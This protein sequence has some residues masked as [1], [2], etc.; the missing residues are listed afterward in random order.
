M[1]YLMREQSRWFTLKKD[2]AVAARL[3]AV[4]EPGFVLI[5][6]TLLA[7]LIL[8]YFSLE[9]VGHYLYGSAIPNFLSASSVLFIELVTRYGFVLGLALLLGLWRGRSIPASYGVT[10]GDY[11]LLKL[12]GIGILMGLLASLPEQILRLVD[13]YVPLGPGTR[14]WALQARVPWNIGFWLYMAVGSFVIVPIFE[15]L[16]TRGYLLGRLRESYS[17]GGSLLA[18]AIFFSL[19][20]GQFH[21]ANIVSVSGEV[22][23][24]FW[25]MILGYAVYRTGSLV[26]AIIAHLIINVPMIVDIRWIIL[27]ISLVALVIWQKTFMAWIID[28]VRLLRTVDDWIWTF[29]AIIVFLLMLITIDKTPWMV[30][31]WLGVF[32]LITLVGLPRRSTWRVNLDRKSI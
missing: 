21:H 32:G 30:F 9:S 28:I 4:A 23:L 16:Y 17:A 22:I 8:S 31:V 19:A 24:F 20:H 2:A 6:G 18:M 11:G 14:F 7:H 27:F 10:L 25:A 29:I 1:E 3:A 13:V 15:E 5:A 26:P 12:I